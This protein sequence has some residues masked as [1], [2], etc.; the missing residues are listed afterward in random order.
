[1]AHGKP[2]ELHHLAGPSAKS[3][4]ASGSTV[5]RT[6]RPNIGCSQGKTRKAASHPSLCFHR[7]E[8]DETPIGRTRSIRNIWLKWLLTLLLVG[9]AAFHS[10]L[11]PAFCQFDREYLE[12]FLEDQETTDLSKKIAFLEQLLAHP[13]DVNRASFG[14]FLQ[15]PGFPVLLARAIVE[16]RKE[17]GAFRTLDEVA[18]IAEVDAETWQWIARFLTVRPVRKC[19]PFLS[20]RSRIEFMLE[21][22]KGFRRGVFPGNPYGLYHRVR[23]S[24]GS[25]LHVG[26][27]SQKDPG[28]RMLTDHLVG[29]AALRLKHPEV[30]V[31]AGSFVLQMGQGLMLSSPL[32]FGSFRSLASGPFLHGQKWRGYLSAYE[33]KYFQ[34]I[35][36][37]LRRGFLTILA[38]YANQPL[39]ASVKNGEIVSLDLSGLHRTAAERSR[40]ERIRNYS[41]GWLV[42]VPFLRRQTFFFSEARFRF[43][44]PFRSAAAWE[45]ETILSGQSYLTLHSTGLYGFAGKWFYFSEGV[46]HARQ[47]MALEAGFTREWEGFRWTVLHRRKASTYANPWAKEEIQAGTGKP[48]EYWQ[49]GFRWRPNPATSLF[50]ATD[51]STFLNPVRLNSPASGIWIR[52]E[53]CINRHH[54][55]YIQ[56]LRKSRI[57][58]T[59]Q[60]GSSARYKNLPILF[61]TDRFRLHQEFTL[62]RRG[63]LYARME[64]SRSAP[65]QS[66]GGI[67]PQSGWLLFWG[68][69]LF[70]RPFLRLDSRLTCFDAPHYETRLYQFEADVPGRLRNVLLY[71]KGLRFYLLFRLNLGKKGTLSA[72]YAVTHYWDRR[73]T[74]SGWDEIESPLRRQ[75]I[76]QLDWTVGTVKQQE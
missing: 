13:L 43:S 67:Q 76:L 21:E 12:R 17:H 8:R 18:R 53:Y 66:A 39:D 6:A 47:L 64:F 42:A 26:V 56:W 60:A 44:H 48:A 14:D 41:S 72:K 40:Q 35:A 31:L 2:D 37:R 15:I 27:L 52:M 62:P 20:A 50:L 24:C 38:W 23:F 32:S 68:I 57:Q 33:A 1:M 75:I 65:A 25:L 49:M 63:R 46:F 22:A 16:H 69:R 61:W 3:C 11:P 34:G 36:A 58:N 5:K 59:G 45:V 4:R 71:G 19:S 74:G 28:E 54:R 7:N 10:N 9:G 70:L 73:S 51:H 29:F 55:L 30:S